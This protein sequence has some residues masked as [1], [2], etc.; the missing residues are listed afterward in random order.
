MCGNKNRRRCQHCSTKSRLSERTGTER[1]TLLPQ[2]GF[3]VPRVCPGR[4]I[5]GTMFFIPLVVCL[6]SLLCSVPVSC[7]D[8]E[9]A[10]KPEFTPSRLIVKHGD[11]VSATCKVCQSCTE[12]LSL[13]RAVG[14]HT[15]SGTTITWTVDNMTQWSTKAI[16]HYRHGE[17]QCCTALNV[18]AYKPPDSVS[19]SLSHSGPMVEAHQYTLRCD[20]QNVAPVQNLVVTFYRGQTPL[21]QLNS[22]SDPQK[23]PQSEGFSL[24]INASR[25][26]DGAQYRCE[27]ELNLGPFGPQP[28]LVVKSQKITTT[29]HYKPHVERSSHPDPIVVTVGDRLQLNCSAEGNPPPSFTWQLPVP[30]RPVPSL[31]APTLI[32]EYVTVRDDGQ[33][34]CFIR[35][36]IGT[37]NGTFNVQVKATTTA[38]TTTATTTTAPT[39]TATTTATTTTATTTTATTTTATTTTTPTTTPTTTTELTPAPSS[40]TS[41]A[42][43]R[44]FMTWFMILFSLVI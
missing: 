16:C 40:S 18:T 36:K 17:T 35:N 21:G 11:S 27:A 38:P 1:L 33:Y 8:Y 4:I 19:I 10:D 29:V 41:I 14:R 34:V 44:W 28:P 26:D 3:H 43:T 24:S 6:T 9:C 2:F 12:L 7:C 20:V 32:I 39:T 13:E 5:G 42:L 31:T 15:T 25:E 23:E 30:W 22:T 37:V